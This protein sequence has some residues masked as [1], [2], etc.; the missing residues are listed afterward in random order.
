MGCHVLISNSFVTLWTVA[1]QTPLSMGLSKENTGVGCHVLISNSFVT[2]W[3][4]ARQTPLSMGLS[5]KNTGVVCHVLLQ[6]IFP[7]QGLNLHLLRLCIGR[8]IIYR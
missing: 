7:N 3:T 6:G 5:R 4:V 8:W 1:R 2:L